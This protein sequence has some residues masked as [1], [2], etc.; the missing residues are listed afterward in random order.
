MNMQNL[1][2]NGLY[3]NGVWYNNTTQPFNSY[4]PAEGG[5]VSVQV[6]VV[7]QATYEGQSFF[8]QPTQLLENPDQGNA[9]AASA[10]GAVEAQAQVQPPVVYQQ[11][12]QMVQPMQAMQPMQMVPTAATNQPD[13]QSAYIYQPY[14][15][16]FQPMQLVVAPPNAPQGNRAQAN[17]VPQNGGQLLGAANVQQAMQVQM[18][19]PMQVPQQMHMQMQQQMQMQMPQPRQ[20]PMESPM[21]APMHQLMQAPMQ[22]QMQQQAL[23]EAPMQASMR[24][25]QAM[26]PAIQHA[27][28]ALKEAPMQVQMQQP[29]QVQMRQPM[30]PQ[31]QQ[32]MPQDSG[33]AAPALA[34]APP[35][36]PNYPYKIYNYQDGTG[37]PRQAAP[38]LPPLPPPPAPPQLAAPQAA[39]QSVEQQPGF[40]MQ[41]C[42]PCCTNP[43]VGAPSAK[44]PAEAESELL[45]IDIAVASDVYITRTNEKLMVTIYKQKKSTKSEFSQNVYINGGPPPEAHV[46]AEPDSNGA[47]VPASQPANPVG[48]IAA[49]PSEVPHEA[50][51]NQA[52][53]LAQMEPTNLC[54]RE[55]PEPKIAQA[56]EMEQFKPRILP[57]DEN[58]QSRFSECNDMETRW[59]QEIRDKMDNQLDKEIEQTLENQL[60]LKMEPKME[61][62]T[63]NST[64]GPYE[65]FRA[66]RR[67]MQPINPMPIARPPRD[68]PKHYRTNFSGY[69]H[70]QS[71][72]REK[73]EFVVKEILKS[74][75]QIQQLSNNNAKADKIPMNGSHLQ[76]EQTLAPKNDSHSK[77]E[78]TLAPKNDFHSKTEQTLAAKNDFHSKTEQTLAAKNDHQLKTEQTL[79][80]KNDSHSKTEQTLAPKNDSQSKTEQTLAPKNDSH[81]KTEQT[82]APKNDFHPKTKKTWVPKNDFHSKT[83]QTWAPKNYSHSKTKQTWVPKNDSHLKTEQTLTVNNVKATKATSNSNQVNSN[84]RQQLSQNSD[85]LIV[86]IAPGNGNNIQTVQDS[87]LIQPL[88]EVSV[89][90]SQAVKPK[91]ESITPE[92]PKPAQGPPQEPSI[93]PNRKTEPK[94]SPVDSP[95]SK[96]AKQDNSKQIQKPKG[97]P[98]IS[99]KQANLLARRNQRP[100][101][102][103]AERS[104]PKKPQSRATF[105]PLIY[106]LSGPEGLREGSSTQQKSAVNVKSAAENS[107]AKSSQSSPNVNGETIKTD[108]LRASSVISRDAPKSSSACNKSSE[109]TPQVSPREPKPVVPEKTY[110]PPSPKVDHRNL[111]QTA[112]EATSSTK[113]QSKLAQ[114]KDQID[115]LSSKCVT[116][117]RASNPVLAPAKQNRSGRAAHARNNASKAPNSKAQ[118]KQKGQTTKKKSSESAPL[119]KSSKTVGAQQATKVLPKVKEPIIIQSVEIIRQ[120]DKTYNQRKSAA[121]DLKPI[122]TEAAGKDSKDVMKNQAILS[123]EDSAAAEVKK[124]DLKPDESGDQSLELEQNKT[125]VSEAGAETEGAISVELQKGFK[126]GEVDSMKT[127]SNLVPCPDSWEELAK[128]ESKVMQPHPEEMESNQVANEEVDSGTIQSFFSTNNELVVDLDSN[129]KTLIMELIQTVEHTLFHSQEV[130]SN[131]NQSTPSDENEELEKSE[132][133]L[134]ERNL[135]SSTSEGTT[136][137]EVEQR[138]EEQGL[139][140]AT[141]VELKESQSEGVTLT[142]INENSPGS[143]SKHAEINMLLTHSDIELALEDANQM[144]N[145]AVSQASSGEPGLELN[146]SETESK[147]DVNR[148]QTKSSENSESTIAANEGDVVNA[149]P[150]EPDKDEAD[151]EVQ[152]FGVQQ[153]STL[154]KKSPRLSRMERKAMRREAKKALLESLAQKK[155]EETEGNDKQPSEQANE[156]QSEKPK[157]N[158]KKKIKIYGF[159]REDSS[160]SSSEEEIDSPELN[161][162]SNPLLR[163]KLNSIIQ[164][165]NKL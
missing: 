21:Q 96:T 109:S 3:H 18:Q 133:V 137:V 61:N 7:P 88:T 164:K 69:K 132:E 33:A 36:E 14:N 93:Q 13:N 31:I 9:G 19:H 91:T 100:F 156:E 71:S 108:L 38:A 127:Q 126:D 77:T 153:R 104:S 82:L 26:D 116:P 160:E 68:E 138:D 73:P 112:N 53:P 124:S 80:P 47:S 146:V 35:V 16:T 130:D 98:R 145:N 58:G 28:Q 40:C 8:C 84:N 32:R 25:Q 95:A 70:G 152:P 107:L 140:G 139:E 151:A 65:Q 39:A 1:P 29:L 6:P 10:E 86:N 129:V 94:K 92:S 75:K 144:E 159:E 54:A 30:D 99:K 2:P 147:I 4:Q 118:A 106:N 66:P 51:A 20:A 48:Y 43:V 12:C 15:Q 45:E 56:N 90:Q 102:L 46:Q 103:Q 157:V 125:E 72:L 27:V 79:T 134:E 105:A 97:I 149:N 142:E 37:Q 89:S 63:E 158:K 74:T 161:D 57:F 155:K 101:Q 41:C 62:N 87:S 115:D 55:Q 110:Q 5:P 119:N 150:G 42:Y 44:Q 165:I 23:K 85:N 60:Q 122:A 120:P 24:M 141:S 83:K 78:Q 121:E 162:I 11:P 148:D 64:E 131:T 76:A 17:G 114:V 34:L 154:K 52:P 49:P 136:S 22:V 135:L 117:A 67:I 163:R 111:E 128:D 50:A 113:V 59:H 143:A 123:T 81:S